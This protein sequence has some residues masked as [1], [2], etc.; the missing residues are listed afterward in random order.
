MSIHSKALLGFAKTI[1]HLDG[2]KVHISEE[3]ITQ[4]SSVKLLEGEGMPEKDSDEKGNLYVRI[5]VH[6]PE[7]TEGELNEL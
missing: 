3:G 1:V 2:R 4:P 7:F 6:I 5:N